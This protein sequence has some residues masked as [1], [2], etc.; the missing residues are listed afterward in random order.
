MGCAR[1]PSISPLARAPRTP[2]GATGRRRRNRLAVLSTTPAIADD[3]A[4][5]TPTASGTAAVMTLP[6]AVPSAEAVQVPTAS[7]AVQIAA[8]DP[9]PRKRPGPLFRCPTED[10]APALPPGAPGSSDRACCPGARSGPLTRP[11]LPSTARP[12]PDPAAR[13]HGPRRHRPT[14]TPTPPPQTRRRPNADA[15]R[16]RP[17]A[18]AGSRPGRDV[19]GARTGSNPARRHPR[20]NSPGDRT[21]P[22]S[23]NPGTGTR[24]SGGNGPPAGRA[25]YGPGTVHWSRWVQ[26]WGSWTWCSL[27]PFPPARAP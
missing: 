22:G 5:P 13:P 14:Q 9:C 6:A 15:K 10:P 26:I 3:A 16:F 19:P 12:R 4:S 20:P 2:T 24:R 27:L 23:H 1:G 7:A 11:A 18:V 21:G 25:R 17:D 8:S